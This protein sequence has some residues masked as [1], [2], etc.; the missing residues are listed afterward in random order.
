MNRTDLFT[1]S[2]QMLSD[3][4]GIRS[5]S[6]KI[7]GV[8]ITDVR[9]SQAAAERIGKPAGRYITLSGDPA[10]EGMT[11]LLRRAIEQL[12]PKSGLILA[13]GLG[14]PD[15]THDALGSVCVKKL[16]AGQGRRHYLAAIETDVALRTG[17]ETPALIRAAAKECGAECVLAIDALACRHPK[18]IGRTVQV[19]S[20]GISPGSGAGGKGAELSQ[21]T[22]KLPVI[23]LGVPTLTELSSVT[24][25]E[26][27]AGYIVSTGDINVIIECW[28][29]VIGGAINE[30]L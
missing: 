13:A 3:K 10:D 12:V 15:V 7:G 28:A 18:Y 9:V 14:N 24:R 19:S 26:A 5:V 20:T 17:I 23:A 1:E 29:E 11:A 27:D 16:L 4:S 30:L 21:Q 25:N 22:V 2:A 8:E 6:R